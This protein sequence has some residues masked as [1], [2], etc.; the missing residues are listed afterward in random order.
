TLPGNGAPSP[1]LS[2]DEQFVAVSRSGRVRNEI[3]VTDM[4]RKTSSPVQFTSRVAA[5]PVW[6]PDGKRLA[7]ACEHGLCEGDVSG[8]GD[9]RVL[10]PGR[11]WP[12]QYTA[13][14]RNILFVNVARLALEL[15]PVDGGQAVQVAPPGVNY[16]PASIAPGG[17]YVSYTSSESGAPEVYVRTLPPATGKW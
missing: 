5:L 15:Q 14:G 13:D 12:Q 17:G 8:E 2:A 3:W 1:A 6:S 16:F 9:V 7:F 11:A 4:A 10:N